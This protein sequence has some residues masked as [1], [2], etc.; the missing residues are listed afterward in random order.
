MFPPLKNRFFHILG[1]KIDFLSD[2][3]GIWALETQKSPKI[4]FFEKKFKNWRENVGNVIYIHF[5][6]IGTN[7]DTSPTL[8]RLFLKKS[9]F[10]PI[11]FTFGHMGFHH[12]P[13]SAKI[14]I[15]KKLPKHRYFCIKLT[16]HIISKGCWRLFAFLEALSYRTIALSN[17]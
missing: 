13:I 14:C 5:G 12:E 7:P 3:E 6:L 1:V 2:F 8:F 10:W 16:L 9:Y 17:A 15:L 11:G 4:G